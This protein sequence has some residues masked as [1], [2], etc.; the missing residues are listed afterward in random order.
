MF[1]PIS[2]PILLDV[3]T[4]LSSIV[5]LTPNGNFWTVP[6]L[7]SVSVICGP[8]PKLC[9]YSDVCNQEVFQISF[10]QFERQNMK[11]CVQNLWK[12]YLILNTVS[13]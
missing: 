11:H 5:V 12:E 9:I 4:F 6:L 3:V 2:L 8:D 13:V 7:H 10:P 1:Q